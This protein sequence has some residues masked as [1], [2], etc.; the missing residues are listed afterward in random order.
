MALVEIDPRPVAGPW[1]A[2]YTLA[3]HTVSSTFLGYDGDRKVFD[4]TYTPLGELVFQFKYRGGPHSSIVDTAAHFVNSRWLGVIDAVTYPPFSIRRASQPTRTIAA[5]I[6]A[7]LGVRL[8]DS[9]VTKPTPTPPIKNV[10]KDQRPEML[11]IAIQPGPDSVQGVRLLLVDDLW[12]TGATMIRVA[13]VLGQAG[14]AD[15][16]VLVMTRTK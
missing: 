4:N 15:V 2:G 16:K 5:E 3:W 10:S 1:S 13:E 11:R 12:Q 6:A 9:A 8:L 14:A 7:R